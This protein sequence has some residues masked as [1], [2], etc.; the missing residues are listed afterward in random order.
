VLTGTGHPITNGE[1]IHLSAWLKQG[2]DWLMFQGRADLVV[3]I[4]FQKPENNFEAAF[5]RV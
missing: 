1:R 4:F 5:S 3:Q 2:R